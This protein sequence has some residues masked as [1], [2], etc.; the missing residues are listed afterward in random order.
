MFD[1]VIVESPKKIKK[2]QEYLGEN[3]K[4]AASVGH[5]RD[6]PLRRMGVEAPNFVPDY[7]VN[8]DKKSVVAN[9]KKLIKQARMVYLATDLDR[10]GEAIAWHLREVLKPA[11]YRRIKFNAIT[12][13]AL[14]ESISNAGDLDMMLVAAQE[15][16]RVLDRI[17][18]YT[19]SPLLTEI[20]GAA[21]NL[22]AGRVQSAALLLLVDREQAIER[23]VS[24]EHYKLKV[25]FPWPGKQAVWHAEWQHQTLQTAM[26]VEATD[27]FTHAPYIASLAEAIK[28]QPAFMVYKVDRREEDRKAPAPFTTST[29]QQAASVKLGMD[30]DQTMK[31]AQALFDAGLIT[32]HR[33][34]SPNLDEESAE[35]IRAWLTGQGHPVPAQRNTWASKADAQEAHEAI[36]PTAV[37]ITPTDFAPDSDEMKLYK[38]IWLRAVASQMVPAR[39]DATKALLLSA[40]QV[41]GSNLQFLAKGRVLLS[42]GWMALTPD[43]AVEDKEEAKDDEDD[44]SLPDLQEQARLQ[45]C[46][47]TPIT[48]ATKPPPR[49]T[50]A[51]L[52]KLLES[53]GIGRPST[54]ASIVATLYK[55]EYI[56][57]ESRKLFAT[58]LGMG[59]ISILRGRFSFINYDFTKMMEGALDQIATGKASY[60]AVV[61]YQHQILTGEVEKIKSDPAIAAVVS[62]EKAKMF[63]DQVSCP[64]CNTGVLRRRT[65]SSGA[66]W[67][68]TAYPACT[69]SCNET[70]PRGKPPE[71]DLSTIR[72]KDT[73]PDTDGPKP[74]RTLSVDR[75]PKCKKHQMSLRTGA[76][77]KFWG[78][79]G[80]PKCKGTAPYEGVDSSES[81]P[82]EV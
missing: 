79:L 40:V 66:F 37:D 78:C 19:V 63:G 25:G 27:L 34:D 13:K 9:L 57:K 20:S 32:Y 39:Y 76:K 55:R 2:V 21:V 68:C 71:P 26:G 5:F 64:I 58:P 61:S 77:G 12:K 41:K 47:V 17:V 7:E 73:T 50:D 80:Y 31:K 35:E 62:E 44:K 82:Q 28:N 10:E 24:V 74:P 4:V 53:M 16:R 81:A 29:L 23:F 70:K 18:G 1:L 36:R 56:R 30:V 67:G 75:C 45:C 22:S 33:T 38:L 69:A 65:T 60:L 46:E 11:K 8:E 48:T 43:D 42:P 6:L 52:T 3:Y 14:T 49:L 15:A 72:T 51:S 54:F 59:V